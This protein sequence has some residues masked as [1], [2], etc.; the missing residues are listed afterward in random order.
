M[1][2]ARYTRWL[3]GIIL[4]TALMG[5]YS[6]QRSKLLLNEVQTLI[7]SIDAHVKDLTVQQF[8]LNGSEQSYLHS[9]LV[10][11]IPSKQQHIL[12]QPHITWAQNNEPGWEIQADSAIASNGGQEITFIQ[13]VVLSK[14]KGSSGLADL[15][16]AMLL[17]ANQALFNQ[18]AHLGVF[19][20][21]VV[22]DQGVTHIHSTEARIELDVQNKLQ[23]VK[24]TG[25]KNIPVHYASVMQ[26]KS[27]VNAY[28]DVMQYFPEKH[29]IQF[30]GNAKLTQ[31][32]NFFSA[33]MIIYDTLSQHIVSSSKGIV[34]TTIVIH[35]ENYS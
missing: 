32:N 12:Q 29:R 24:L 19:N 31:N 21:N 10:Q 18:Q 15:K 7:S 26:N 16:D 13:N 5:W 11:R 6:L 22:I 23:H 9:E 2:I 4:C 35:P 33:P 17:H 3:C 27:K 8:D 20:G 28:A 30:I 34:R 25:T 1:N 14:A